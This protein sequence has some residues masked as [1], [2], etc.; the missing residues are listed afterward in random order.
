MVLLLIIHCLLLLPL[1]EG[2]LCLVLV[3]N[4]VHNPFYFNNHLAEELR[5]GPGAVLLYLYSCCHVAFGAL[6]DM[7]WSVFYDPGIS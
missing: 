4:V 1:F 6:C 3:C 2:V 5:A 7:G